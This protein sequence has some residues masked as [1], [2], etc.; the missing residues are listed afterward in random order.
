[1][2]ESEA[3]ID[4]ICARGGRYLYDQYLKP[5]IKPYSIAKETI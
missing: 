4:E 2:K 5:K 1:M 3:I